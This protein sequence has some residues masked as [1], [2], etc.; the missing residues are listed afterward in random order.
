LVIQNK[1][2]KSQN[3]IEVNEGCTIESS[4]TTNI[5]E[6]IED[7]NEIVNLDELIE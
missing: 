4:N 6:V 7:L 1:K 5:Q 3:V 2:G